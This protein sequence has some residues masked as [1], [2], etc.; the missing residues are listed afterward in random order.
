MKKSI[1]TISFIILIV[2]VLC[3]AG[4]ISSDLSA[5]READTMAVRDALVKY[6]LGNVRGGLFSSDD[7]TT[8]S[9]SEEEIQ[10]NIDQ[11]NQLIDSA[12]ALENPCRTQYR[13]NHEFLLREYFKKTSDFEYVDSGVSDIRIIDTK[14]EARRMEV[15]YVSSVWF[16]SVSFDGTEYHAYAAEGRNYED[17]EMVHEDGMWKVRKVNELIPWDCSCYEENEVREWVSSMNE[18]MPYSTL[19]SDKRN[20]DEKTKSMIYDEIKRNQEITDRSFPSFSEAKEAAMGM[21]ILEG[22]YYALY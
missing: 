17:V 20:I 15:K 16:K 5:E 12:Y 6:K 2:S 10:A 3:F 19:F 7:G 9:L 21:N 1:V 18:R 11:Y 13:E 4:F 22:N 8:S 14:M